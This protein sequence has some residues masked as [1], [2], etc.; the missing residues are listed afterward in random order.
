MIDY[1]LLIIITILNGEKYYCAHILR[2]RN[3]IISIK[4]K[5]SSSYHRYFNNMC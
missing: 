2:N 5:R 4:F 1:S 3:K